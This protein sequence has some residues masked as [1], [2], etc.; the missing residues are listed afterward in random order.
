MNLLPQESHSPTSSP[1][2][3]V[4]KRSGAP[5]WRHGRPRA[6]PLGPRSSR[7]PPR[8]G[9]RN[10]ASSR[11]TNSVDVSHSG[12]LASSDPSERARKRRVDPHSAHSGPGGPSTSA[13]SEGSSASVR[14]ATPTGID[15]PAR[16]VN[17]CPHEEQVPVRSRTS[18]SVYSTVEPQSGQLDVMGPKTRV[19]PGSLA[20]LGAPVSYSAPL[21]LPKGAS[22]RADSL[23]V[24]R[25]EIE[26]CGSGTG[27]RPSSS[28][29][30]PS[31]SGP[32]ENARAAARGRP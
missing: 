21:P 11:G 27:D 16:N 12:Q 18:R 13:S 20:R 32:Q 17:S 23:G 10:P 31:S 3:F 25:L 9:E 7:V 29:N 28:S 26:G 30:P 22:L 24:L 2:S 1:S 5:H 19:G 6:P 4:E 15:A 8:R 14:A